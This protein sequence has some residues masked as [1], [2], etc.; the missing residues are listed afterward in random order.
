MYLTQPCLAKGET[1]QLDH[2]GLQ[3]SGNTQPSKL[4]KFTME[5]DYMG[6]NNPF[7]AW[8]WRH[9]GPVPPLRSLSPPRAIHTS[10]SLSSPTRFYASTSIFSRPDPIIP[11]HPLTD[12]FM[13]NESTD[14]PTTP[15]RRNYFQDIEN[16]NNVVVQPR[17]PE[18]VTFMHPES[19]AHPEEN[20]FMRS[21]SPTGHDEVTSMPPDPPAGLVY[22][23][24]ESMD[25]GDEQSIDSFAYADYEAET[26]ETAQNDEVQQLREDLW[27]LSL[28]QLRAR[29]RQRKKGVKGN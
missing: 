28:S 19:P 18:E 16:Y 13:T 24:Y 14:R 4:P 12:L 8:G 17:G 10:S 20:T 11:T 2:R 3:A 26:E 25:V 22:D 5:N 7:T 29:L 15:T 1:L 21:E 23:E 9:L 6:N 27:D